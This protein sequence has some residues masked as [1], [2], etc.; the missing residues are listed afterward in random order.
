[1]SQPFSDTLNF[2]IASTG[3]LSAAPYLLMAI[4]LGLCGILSD[5]LKNKEYLTTTQIRKLFLCGSFTI[6]GISLLIVAYV[7]DP[8]ICVILI[9]ISIGAGAGSLSGILSGFF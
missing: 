3:V 6:Q 7:S 4:L 1:L 2:Q 8:D 9:T 5:W